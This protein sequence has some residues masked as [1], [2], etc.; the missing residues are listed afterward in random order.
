MRSRTCS[1]SGTE[2]DRIVVL[3]ELEPT[4]PTLTTFVPPDPDVT[5]TSAE[6]ALLVDA[7]RLA[8]RRGAGPFRSAGRIA[9]QPRAYQLVHLIMTLRQEKVR[10]LIAD[11]VGLGKTIE[12]GLTLREMMDRGEVTRAAIL[13]PPH[14]VEQ[15]VEELVLKFDLYATAVPAATAPRLERGLPI[16]E[17][18]FE[19]HTLTVISLDYIKTDSRRSDFRR[20]CPPFVIVDEA[21]A[22]VGAFGTARSSATQRYRL[23]ADLAE[24]VGRHIVLLTAAPHSGDT[25]AFNNL[26]GLINSS[27]TSGS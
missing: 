27:F 15:W 4:P 11:D 24:D 13:C 26:V 23:L 9:F 12:A 20:K 22:C 18:L 16:N 2:G 21:H 3:P 14:L 17:S 5:G 8:L 6:A 19:V 7:L 1:L 25:D 10:L